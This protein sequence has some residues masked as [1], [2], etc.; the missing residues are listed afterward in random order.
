MAITVRDILMLR[1]MKNCIIIAGK[2]G[3]DNIVEIIDMLEFGWEANGS[4]S[5]DLFDEQSFVLSSLIFARFDESKLYPTIRRLIECGVSGLA[6]KPVF[7]NELPSDVCRL[8]NDNDFPIFRFDCGITFREIICDVTDIIKLNRNI[9]EVSGYFSLMMYQ[10]LKKDEVSQI[11]NKIS[12][13][14]LKNAKVTIITDLENDASFSVNCIMRSFQA[15][16]YLDGNIVLCKFKSGLALITTMD[17][18]ENDKYSVV[19]DI[20]FSICGINRKSI[21][22]AQSRIHPTYT[23]LDQ[24][25]KEAYYAYIANKVL[26]KKDLTY[27]GIGTLSFLIPTVSNSHMQKYMSEFLSPIFEDEIL[28]QTAITFVQSEGNYEVAS[29]KL[30]YH[31]N[32]VRYRINKIQSMLAVELPYESFFENLSIAIKIYLIKKV[33]HG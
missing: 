28:L 11:T 12:P 31:K 1:S 24:C 13:S 17:D 27:D 32:T 25:V 26:D 18:R 19:L 8:A 23:A 10:D 3:M 14:L 6:Y 15:S 33:L 21:S 9:L 30:K 5:K 20:V 7:F 22:L 2:S 16:H 4:Y 29:K